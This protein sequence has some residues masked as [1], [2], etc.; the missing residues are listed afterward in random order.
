LRRPPPNLKPAFDRA[1]YT[2]QL[3]HDRNSFTFAA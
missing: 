3:H 2:A 1:L